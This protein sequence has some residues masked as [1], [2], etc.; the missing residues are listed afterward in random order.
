MKIAEYIAQKLHELGIT[1][2]FSVVGG[3]AMH[4]NDAFA[5]TSGIN[6]TYMHHEQACSIAAEGY[7]RASGKTACV[8]VTTGPGG[9]NTLTGVM[10][11]WTDSIPVIY[12][13][14]QVNELTTVE[15]TG[16]RELRQLGDQEVHII[17]VV[18]P[19]TKMAKTLEN[20]KYLEWNIE[21][22]W[23]SAHAG[24]PGPVW[25][26]VP[27]NVQGAEFKP[28][29]IHY[30][31]LPP[32]DMPNEHIEFILSMINKAKRPLIIAGHGIRIAKACAAFK[33]FASFANIPVVTTFNGFD[34]LTSKHWCH[35]G[36]IT[37]LGHRAANFILQNADVILILGSRNNIRQVSYKWENFAPNAIK[38]CIDIDNWELQKPTIHIQ[39]QFHADVKSFLTGALNHMFLQPLAKHTEW[40]AWC[41]KLKEKY[42]IMQKKFSDDSDGINL[43]TFFNKATKNIK[44][45][46]IGVAGNGSACVGLFQAGVV[47]N[48][49]RYFWNSGC[50]AMGY[51][52]PAAIG[53]SIATKRPVWCFDG[54]GS[55]QLNIQELQ[56]IVQHKLN[57]TIFYLNNDGFSSIKQT[58]DNFFHRRAG[59][60]PA[61]GITFPRLE[62]IAQAYGITYIKLYNHK[63]VA[64]WTKMDIK[65][66]IIFEVMLQKDYSFEPKLAPKMLEDGT[67]VA[68]SFENMYPFL[69]QEE[70]D[71]NMIGGKNEKPV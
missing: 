56:T 15:G 29:S 19:L 55:F 31:P 67:I 36:N 5:N 71:A 37:N 35:M 59:C 48:A 26:N 30:E 51:A 39:H 65:G 47:T 14:G 66:P 7:Q 3:G 25:L 38:M 69:P 62:S 57:V 28:A 54:D 34:L 17:D 32:K 6:V 58:Q 22:A 70:I 50:A 8:V 63:D 1:Q 60:D 4:L 52:L 64:Y 10:G 11:Q 2:V 45:L 27:L 33:S 61:S 53:A 18:K 43:Y 16:R 68:P 23:W 42:P 12:V 41:Q 24:R 13:S 46:T 20:D 44:P 9:L 21:K 49:S 40:L